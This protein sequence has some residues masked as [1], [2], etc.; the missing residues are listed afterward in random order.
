MSPFFHCMSQISQANSLIL[1]LFHLNQFSLRFVSLSCK[2]LMTH[3]G[4]VQ[5]LPYLWALYFLPCFMESAYQG[6]LEKEKGVVWKPVPHTPLM[7]HLCLFTGLLRL[8]GPRSMGFSMSLGEKVY[9]QLK[10]QLFSE[11]M[12]DMDPNSMLFSCS[13]LYMEFG[14]MCWS[15]SLEYVVLFYTETGAHV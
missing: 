5:P 7:Y 6:V 2:T 9:I 11:S 8:F 3:L 15:L 10:N 13:R 1:H 14:K 12:K 4:K